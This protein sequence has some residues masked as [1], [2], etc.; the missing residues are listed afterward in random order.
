LG[1]RETRT[2]TRGE[3][4]PCWPPADRTMLQIAREEALGILHD[5]RPPPLPPGA[6]DKIKAIVADADGALLPG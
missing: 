3:Y 2:F 1:Q 4:V 6:G 5:H